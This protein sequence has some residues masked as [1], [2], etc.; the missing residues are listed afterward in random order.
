MLHCFRPWQLGALDR[1]L[2]V[3][4]ERISLGLNNIL[5]DF[6][7]WRCACV[8]LVERCCEHM[9]R[10]SCFV[11]NK[12]AQDR[13]TVGSGNRIPRASAGGMRRAIV[14]SIVLN[15]TIVASLSSGTG[16]QIPWFLQKSPAIL[17]ADLKGEQPI[18]LKFAVKR[19]GKVRISR[20]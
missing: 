15:I 1:I 12:K 4:I 20:F 7:A 16:T 11:V 5:F 9:F 14:L 2:Q 6:A 17:I 13:E 18:P 8:G 3:G 19:L 10:A